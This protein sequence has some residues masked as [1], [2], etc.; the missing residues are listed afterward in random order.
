MRLTSDAN[1]PLMPY[2]CRPQRVLRRKCHAI[3]FYAPRTRLESLIVY[4]ITI[5]STAFPDYFGR[6]RIYFEAFRDFVA[7]D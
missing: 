4:I 5:A 2:E 6:L 7:A 1:A 3:Y